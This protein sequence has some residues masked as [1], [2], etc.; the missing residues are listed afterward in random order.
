M[1]LITWNAL[2]ET[3][4]QEIDA[5]HLQLVNLINRL[6]DTVTQQHGP[7][8]VDEALQTV[9][10]YT[11]FH[12][13]NEEALMARAGYDGVEEHHQLHVDM[14]HTINDFIARHDVGEAGIAEALLDYLRDW[15]VRH[16]LGSDR[17]VVAYLLRQQKQAT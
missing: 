15:L 4:V 17:A 12:F 9:R 10:D 1:S 7:D 3:G 8:I 14:V 5:E 2:L 6:Y 11:L 13:R 16:I